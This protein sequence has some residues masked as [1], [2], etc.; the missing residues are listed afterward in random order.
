MKI[1][2]EELLF[3]FLKKIKMMRDIYYWINLYNNIFRIIWKKKKKKIDSIY[4]IFLLNNFYFFDFWN[5]NINSVIFFKCKM[6][7]FCMV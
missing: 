2:R 3:N 4:K 1:I 6:N 7:Y 5:F